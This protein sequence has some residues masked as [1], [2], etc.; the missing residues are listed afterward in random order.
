MS[1]PSYTLS[2]GDARNQLSSPELL[3]ISPP[4]Y[5]LLASW[6]CVAITG[7]AATADSGRFAHVLGV[8]LPNHHEPTMPSR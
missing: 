2:N 3:F 6:P 7:S 5:A 4:G 8:P 1:Q